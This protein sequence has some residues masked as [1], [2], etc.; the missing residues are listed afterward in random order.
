MQG[1]ERHR[2]QAISIRSSEGINDSNPHLVVLERD[3]LE[4]AVDDRLRLE[5]WGRGSDLGGHLFFFL[6]AER[7][8]E[9]GGRERGL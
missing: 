6:P 5:L 4:L 1:V 7:K 9:E 8:K 3:G 2:G